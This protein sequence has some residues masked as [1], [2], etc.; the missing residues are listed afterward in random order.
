MAI[1]KQTLQKWSLGGTLPKLL[2]KLNSIEKNLIAMAT[3]RKTI[4]DLLR[5]IFTDPLLLPK[6]LSRMT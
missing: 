5:Q 4:K 1:Y 3:N 2:K 6:S